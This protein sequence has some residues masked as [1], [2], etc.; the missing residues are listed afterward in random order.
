MV[1]W[2]LEGDG[3]KYRRKG[4]E[5]GRKWAGCWEEVGCRLIEGGLRWLG[6]GGL[7]ADSRWA[8]V[9]GRRWAGVVER[10]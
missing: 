3:P 4:L 1:G 5:T 10:R 2:R 6:G 9:V 8:E 7:L